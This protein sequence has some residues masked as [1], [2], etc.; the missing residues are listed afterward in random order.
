MDGGLCTHRALDLL[1]ILEG[2]S[3]Q[4]VEDSFARLELDV[5]NL[6]GAVM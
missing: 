4:Q 5:G 3:A 1:A 6:H 2:F